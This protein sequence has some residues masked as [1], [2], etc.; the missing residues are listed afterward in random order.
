M[1]KPEGCC[2]GSTDIPCSTI[3]VH[4][5]KRKFL[6]VKKLHNFKHLY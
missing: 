1:P 5:H 4:F 6:L 2:S 3:P